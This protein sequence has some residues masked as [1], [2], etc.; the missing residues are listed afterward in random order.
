MLTAEIDAS[1]KR[2]YQLYVD[3]VN[4]VKRNFIACQE[5]IIASFF[6]SSMSPYLKMC[7]LPF[8]AESMPKYIC[9]KREGEE[10]SHYIQ[11]RTVSSKRERFTE[12]QI[13]ICPEGQ[14][15]FRKW[16]QG[17]RVLQAGDEIP[18]G[19]KKMYSSLALAHLISLEHTFCSHRRMIHEELIESAHRYSGLQESHLS[20]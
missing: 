7:G 17:V 6:Q 19:V 14:E 13:P 18:A 12:T 4:T 11:P 1:E 20:M 16:L 5:R 15:Q 3:L 8:I 10:L 9:R 2:Q